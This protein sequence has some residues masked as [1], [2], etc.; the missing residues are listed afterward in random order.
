MFPQEP[1]TRGFQKG[2]LPN[3]RLCPNWELLLTAAFLRA[4]RNY[5]KR[6]WQRSKTHWLTVCILVEEL[7]KHLALVFISSMPSG[8]GLSLNLVKL[9]WMWESC[10]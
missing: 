5:S 8:V 9:K 4:G 1:L 6:E 3:R 2:L 7:T 10:L